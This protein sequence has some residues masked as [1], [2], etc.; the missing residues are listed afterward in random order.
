MSSKWISLA[1]FLAVAVGISSALGVLT[2][3]GE[4]YAALNKPVFNPPNWIFGPVWTV[5]Y[6]CIAFAGWLVWL[7]EP[8]GP[9]MAVWA[10]QMLLNW[11]WSPVFFRLQSIW[12]AAVVILAIF[13]L[14]VVFIVLARRVDVRAS[15][16]FLPYAAWV[17]FASGLN[18]S[19]GLLN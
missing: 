10:A 9:A 17:G 19:I 6:F 16:L 1:L 2:L 5:L 14:I 11:V 3:P 15:W 13:A 12:L 4:W 18:I 8:R 7:K